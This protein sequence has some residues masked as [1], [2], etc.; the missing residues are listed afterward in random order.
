MSTIFPPFRIKKILPLINESNIKIL[1]IGSGNHSA[2]ITKKWIPHC[3]YTGVDKD[4][5]YNNNA[6]DNSRMDNFIEL[7]LTQ[8]KFDIIPDNYFDIIIMIHII[9]HLHNGEQVLLGLM[10]KLKENGIFYI[11]FP[12]EKS[13]HFPS[14]RGTLNFFDDSTHCRIYSLTEI[15]NIFMKFNFKIIHAGKRRSLFNIAVMPIKIIVQLLIKGYVEAGVFWDL[16][17][18]ADY[19][20]ARKI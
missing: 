12:S 1:D 14:M 3:H 11:E 2:S 10:Q 7:D 8:L 6:L 4:R 17:G 15:C 5:S 20:V 16:Y 9:E 19:V 18:F 13:I